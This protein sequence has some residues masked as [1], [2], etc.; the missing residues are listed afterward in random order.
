MGT[1]LGMFYAKSIFS[2]F[3]A[4]FLSIKLNY[5]YTN[6]LF[7]VRSLILCLRIELPMLSLSSAKA[8]YTSSCL[9]LSSFGLSGDSLSL[10][11][12]PPC[13]FLILVLLLMSIIVT[14]AAGTLQL[15]WFSSSLF[16]CIIRMS[17]RLYRSI[18]PSSSWLTNYELSEKKKS[19]LSEP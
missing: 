9:I 10:F 7:S 15:S 12:L 1:C 16:F 13:S 14:S 4:S 8:N 17:S 5:Y 6:V 11:H 19:L 2:P 3:L 18:S